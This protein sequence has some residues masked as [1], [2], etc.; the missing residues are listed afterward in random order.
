MNYNF[1]N[2]KYHNCINAVV[3]CYRYN[4]SFFIAQSWIIRIFTT[5]PTM[6]RCH[7]AWEIANEI[8]FVLITLFWA[9]MREDVPWRMS[10]N[11]QTYIAPTKDEQS[12]NERSLISSLSLSSRR[13]MW[14]CRVASRDYLY[15][16]YLQIL[17]VPTIS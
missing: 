10:E 8:R 3:A 7:N 15:I 13:T 14:A 6:N 1:E 17:H 12:I 2:F 11:P 9:D 5:W 16:I 4:T